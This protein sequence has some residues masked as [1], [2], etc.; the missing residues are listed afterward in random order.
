MPSKLTKTKEYR[1]WS[2]MKSRCNNKNDA[3]YS[4]YGGRGIKVCDI[5]SNSFASFIEDMGYAPNSDYSLDRI[6][7]NG[8]YSPQ[9]C[10]W[11]TWEVQ[12]KNRDST[13][14][15]NGKSLREICR[16]R[17]LHMANIK[18]RL[19]CLNWDFERAINTPTKKPYEEM[20]T[21]NLYT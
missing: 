7:N 12:Y 11:T 5:W 6:D 1:T 3:R 10:R 16:E 9:N 21:F 2:K 19:N 17:N 18:N 4:N 20:K 13:I 15:Y 8:D 14:K